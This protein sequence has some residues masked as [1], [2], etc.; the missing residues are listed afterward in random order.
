MLKLYTCYLN[1]HIYGRGS[2]EYMLE[3]FKDY[4][5][6]CEMYGKKEVDIKI[7]RNWDGEDPV[8]TTNV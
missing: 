7:K 3:L 4:V 5:V 1:G 8:G 2:L 6:T